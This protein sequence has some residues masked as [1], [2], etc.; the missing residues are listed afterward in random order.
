MLCGRGAGIKPASG[1]A[2]DGGKLHLRLM[3][4]VN[5]APLGRAGAIIDSG[6]VSNRDRS[7]GCSCLAARRMIEIIEQGEA[8]TALLEFGDGGRIETLDT[9]GHSIFGVI[10]QKVA[11]YS[12]QGVRRAYPSG[13]TDAPLARPGRLAISSGARVANCSAWTPAAGSAAKTS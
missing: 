12:A 3:V 2:W 4:P 1:M 5:G 9:G 13:G 10:D 7:V 11:K 8:R 6:T